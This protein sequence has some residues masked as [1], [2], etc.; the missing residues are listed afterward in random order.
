MTEIPVSAHKLPAR[1]EELALLLVFIP[2][3]LVLISVA[4]LGQLVGLH[5]KGWLPGAENTSNV[6]SGAKAAVYALLSHIS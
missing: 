6:V 4:L 5:W 2:C 3:F 1:R